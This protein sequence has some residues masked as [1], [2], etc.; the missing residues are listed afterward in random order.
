LWWKNLEK[1]F[2]TELVKNVV[3]FKRAKEESIIVHKL[4]GKS[5]GRECEK[6]E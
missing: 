4:K 6:E 2:R 1:F 3:N 5:K